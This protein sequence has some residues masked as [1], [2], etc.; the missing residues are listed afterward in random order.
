MNIFL[1]SCGKLRSTVRFHKFL[2]YGFIIIFLN[3]TIKKKKTKKRLTLF[4]KFIKRGIFFRRY[5]PLKFFSK[6]IKD[7]N[8]IRLLNINL[9]KEEYNVMKT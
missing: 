4:F 5:T 2:L 6:K 8:Q 9:K 1:F 3:E 7:F